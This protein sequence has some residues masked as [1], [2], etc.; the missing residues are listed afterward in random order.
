MLLGFLRGSSGVGIVGLRNQLLDLPL[1]Q[2][3]GGMGFPWGQVFGW[4]RNVQMRWSSS[5]LMMCSNLQACVC[6]SE[7]SMENVSLKRRS[8]RRW[9]RITSRARWLPT[10]V[11]CT[12]PFSIC[13]KCRSDMRE[14]TRVAGSSVTTG[15]FPA[16]PE[17]WSRSASAGFP[18]SPQTQIC[19]SR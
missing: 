9:R 13:T 15:S 18:S 11:S 12:S 16:G 7:S 17:A 5:G 14:S 3:P 2:S 1:Q 10:G 6:A 19:S 8:A 4:P